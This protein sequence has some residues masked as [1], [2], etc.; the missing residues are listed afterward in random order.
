MGKYITDEDVKVRLIGKVRFSED[1]EEK[2][3]M[4]IS[5]LRR[6]ISEAESEVELDLSPRYEVPF[7]TVE[8]APYRALP[9]TTRDIIRTLCELQA[10]RRVLETDFGRGTIVSGDA[11]MD[12]LEQRYNKI[13]ERLME[14]WNEKV[15]PGWKY[16]PLKGL[17]L[18]YFNTEADDGYAGMPINVT[19]SG[20]EGRFP[21]TRINEPSESWWNA[22]S[23]ESSE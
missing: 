19:P 6:L 12:K 8:A 10:V 4:H 18:G 21:S 17:M 14:R 22:R 11:Y 15:R 9:Q 2:N 20:D 13:I 3:T 23:E 5:L 16:P 1:P 7:Q